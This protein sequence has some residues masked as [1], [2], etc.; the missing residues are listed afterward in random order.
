MSRV[1]SHSA[2]LR[3]RVEAGEPF[4]VRLALDQ[5]LEDGAS[6]VSGEVPALA[7]ASSAATGC[8]TPARISKAVF[9]STPGGRPIRD[10]AA[11]SAWRSTLPNPSSHTDR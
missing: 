7:P 10:L 1:L 5:G 3:V 2:P 8:R 6:P 9:P 4:R 11:S